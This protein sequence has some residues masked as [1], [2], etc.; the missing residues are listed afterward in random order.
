MD[1]EPTDRQTHWRDR[2]RDFIEANVRPNLDTYAKQDAEG[3]RW[4]VLQ[5]IEDQ[6]AK[7]RDAGIWNLFMPPRGQLSHVDDTMSSKDRA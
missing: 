7:A 3:E 5:V 2:V 6:K 4:K 1:F